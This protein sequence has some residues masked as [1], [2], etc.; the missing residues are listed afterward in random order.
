[1]NS[2]KVPLYNQ[3]REALAKVA[4]FLFLDDEDI[5]QEIAMLSQCSS[6]YVTKY[7][8]SYLK[9]SELEIVIEHLGGGSALDLLQGLYFGTN[10]FLKS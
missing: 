3:E 10:H 2:W 5:Q 7:F 6:P 1:M 8:A 4:L 9:D